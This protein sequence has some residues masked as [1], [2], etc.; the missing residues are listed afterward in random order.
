MC[1]HGLE[2]Y[3]G[4]YSVYRFVLMSSVT[5]C[6]STFIFVLVHVV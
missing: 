3:S 5:M 1:T 6:M 2:V 4:S